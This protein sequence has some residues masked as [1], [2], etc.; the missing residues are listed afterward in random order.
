MSTLPEPLYTALWLNMRALPIPIDRSKP[1]LMKL[2][3]A[4]MMYYCYGPQKS[5]VRIPALV[6]QV[7][8]VDS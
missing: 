1:I 2:T 8:S 3:R 6:A 7:L 4:H 5:G